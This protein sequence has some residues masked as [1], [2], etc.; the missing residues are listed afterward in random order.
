MGSL[1]LVK[2]T[3]AADESSRRLSL[4]RPSTTPETWLVT[5]GAGYIGAHVVRALRAA[6][7][8]VVVL[9]DLS[10]GDRAAVPDDVPL[11]EGSILDAP[12]LQ[13]VLRE[14][15]VVGVMHLAAQKSV[16][17]S[18]VEPA[19][20][21]RQNVEGTLTVVESMVA[22]GVQNLV[23]ASSAAI[24]GEAAQ[25][26]VDETVLPHDLNPY[27][28]TK[29]V[30]EWVARDVARAAGLRVVSLRYFNVAG[31]ASEHLRDRARVGLV[32]KVVD[33]VLDGRP[34]IVF[35]TDHPT[36]DGTCVRDYVHVEDLARAHVLAA[37]ALLSGRCGTT[38]NVGSGTGVSVR[39]VIDAVGA[40]TGRPVQAEDAPRREGDPSDVIACI[41]RIT[42]ELDWRPTKGLD[43]IIASELVR[44]HAALVPVPRGRVVIISASVGAGH[45]GAA[46]EWRRRLEAAGF[47]AE[48]HD[49]LTLLPGFVG[50][51]ISS[52][53]EAMLH[54]TPWVYELIYRACEHPTGAAAVTRALLRPFQKGMARVVTDDT[55]A[56]LSTYPLSSQ[57][58]GQLRLRGRLA[59][60][61]ATFLTDFSVHR[62]WV[63]PGIDAHL[64]L[65]ELSAEQ[66]ER[67]G[68]AGVHVTG[69]LVPDRFRDVPAGTTRA[70]DRARFDLPAQAPL[71]LLVAGSWGVGDV[72]QTARDVIAT[73]AATPVI[74]CGR[75]DELRARLA[76]ADIGHPLGWV[77]DM[78]ALL[79]AVDVLV[80]NAGGLSSLEAM[81]AG[82]PVVT[83]RPI[84][85]HGRTN[86]ATLSE[87]GVT[88][89]VTRA[90][91]LAGALT[92][93]IAGTEGRDQVAR[94][95]ALFQDD[96]V[97]AIET[98]V[99][100]DE[101]ATRRSGG[102]RG[103]AVRRWAGRGVAAAALATVM[104]VAG[105]TGAELAVAKGLNAVHTPPAG[106]V[107]VIVHPADDT[108]LSGGTIADLHRTHAAVAVDLAYLRSQPDSVRRLADAHVPLVNAAAGPPY[109][110]GML[111]GRGAIRE[112]AEG[113]R[114]LTGVRPRLYLSGR[115][116][117]A[118]DLALAVSLHERFVQPTTI[119]SDAEAVDR[120]APGQI[121]LL[122]C[123]K[124]DDSLRESLAAVDERT[125]HEGGSLMAATSLPR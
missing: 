40:A 20:Y 110:T 76:A 64:A 21:Y 98:M 62:L 57:I 7:R 17:A 29:L 113:I 6:D 35:G 56:V 105:T 10:T 109:R 47:T 101:L 122:E 73:G 41:E 95:R 31:A 66:A 121:V 61:A 119:V 24:Y 15:G 26:R 79:R 68:A 100:V 74:V 99:P 54:R 23:L 97:S 106:S 124:N 5:G 2:H 50:R 52:T 11:V 125:R 19:L 118:A 1:L 78:P 22:A 102:S 116:L 58:L 65:H 92:A 60:P 103:S 63:A 12:L 33:A 45:D 111:R 55:V 93:I 87:A 67:L 108:A 9:D 42:A 77:D 107:S 89:Y 3:S 28:A 91:D 90:E 70:A 123:V 96:P 36:P 75:N 8:P 14:H 46:R 37:E 32:P 82:V 80:E 4:I 120:V 81:A 94:G 25:G 114:D 59:V 69:P 39:Q 49:F 117:D 51:R 84:P 104:T 88:R 30:S 112:T 48:V 16:P 115:H 86:A 27:G 34:P 83:Y 38:Y 13:R 72:E 53:Y 18:I 43:E 44:P 85:G 71:A